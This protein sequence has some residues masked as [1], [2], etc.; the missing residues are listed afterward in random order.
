M[1]KAREILFHL[2]RAICFCT[3]PAACAAALLQNHQKV[4]CDTSH[5]FRFAIKQ[6]TIG[7]VRYIAPYVE[8]SPIFVLK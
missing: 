1:N 3:A 7:M 4:G 2:G 5:R 8:V 6:G